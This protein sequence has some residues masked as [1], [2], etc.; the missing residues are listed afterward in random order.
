MD[1]QEL[2]AD[3]KKELK[4]V[5][6]FG[7]EFRDFISRGNVVDLAVGVII[8]GAFGK[9]VSSLVD[10]ILMPAVGALA[11]GFNFSTLSVTVG[12]ATIG[13]GSFIQ[14]VI[15]FLIIAACIFVFV[16]F[17]SGLR[18]LGKTKTEVEDKT[19]H[20]KEDEQLAVLREIRDTLK[21][22]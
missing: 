6:K 2:E 22:K 15:D 17:M 10:D 14:N 1:K 5:K 21:K 19:A 9:I 13:Y 7:G 12:Q 16:K 3:I 11:G 4:V 18:N 8:G 20:K